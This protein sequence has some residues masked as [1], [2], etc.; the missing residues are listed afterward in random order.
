MLAKWSRQ[1]EACGY[2]AILIKLVRTGSD[3]LYLTVCTS[4]H[5]SSSAREFPQ[6][7]ISLILTR[8]HP[9][10]S[11]WSAYALTSMIVDRLL[12]SLS[13]HEKNSGSRLF[14]LLTL[15][16]TLSSQK[17][18]VDGAIA[19]SFNSKMRTSRNQQ[20]L[21]RWLSSTLSLAL[22]TLF[23]QAAGKVAMLPSPALPAVH[24]MPA[25]RL[26]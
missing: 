20:W 17:S 13:T 22:H 6:G 26:S 1:K 16:T 10:V 24:A 23:A 21:V 11:I 19:A 25:H 15:F 3:Q 4:L 7:K 5:L 14:A 18:F 2:A 8:S 9:A 12:W